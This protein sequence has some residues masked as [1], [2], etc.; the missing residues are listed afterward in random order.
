MMNDISL[1]ELTPD[2]FDPLVLG[3]DGLVVVYFR[4]SASPP[5]QSLDTVL[6]S[7]RRKLGSEVNF[8]LVNVDQ[9]P[10][11]ATRFS[12][13]TTPTLLIFNNGRVEERIVGVSPE[14]DLIQ[15]IKKWII[16]KC[17]DGPIKP[18]GTGPVTNITSW[19]SSGSPLSQ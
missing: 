11:P 19:I 17:S 1:C 12:V 16:G 5:C 9:N 7:T 10:S 8:W 18:E 14:T 15:K 3:D 4:S 13:D 6:N 2:E